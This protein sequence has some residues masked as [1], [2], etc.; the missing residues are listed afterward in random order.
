MKGS[1]SVIYYISEIAIN[2]KILSVSSSGLLLVGTAT[3]CNTSGYFSVLYQVVG[4]FVVCSLRRSLFLIS[5]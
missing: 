3:Q 5:L 1:F 4:C 2:C